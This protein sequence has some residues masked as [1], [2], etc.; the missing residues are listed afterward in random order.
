MPSGPELFTSFPRTNWR[1]RRTIAGPEGVHGS[2]LSFQVGRL[3]ER[4][5]RRRSGDNDIPW[6]FAG[7]FRILFTCVRAVPF[8]LSLSGPVCHPRTVA[9]SSQ[10]SLRSQ[11]EPTASYALPIHLF[12]SSLSP[13]LSRLVTLQLGRNFECK[14]ERGSMCEQC[15]ETWTSLSSRRIEFND[16]FCQPTEGFHRFIRKTL[17][18]ISQSWPRIKEQTETVWHRSKHNLLCY[19]IFASTSSGVKVLSCSNK[20]FC[21]SAKYLLLLFITK[22]RRRPRRALSS[23]IV[24]TSTRGRKVRRRGTW[25]KAHTK[26]REKRGPSPTSSPR[27][28]VYVRV[29]TWPCEQVVHAW[30]HPAEEARS[31]GAPFRT[32]GDP[33]RNLGADVVIHPASS[34]KPRHPASFQASH[35]GFFRMEF[36]GVWS[37][38][39]PRWPAWFVGFRFAPVF[40]SA[41]F[42]ETGIQPVNVGL[43]ENN[44]SLADDSTN[45]VIGNRWNFLKRTV[46]HER[47]RRM[48]RELVRYARKNRWQSDS[49]GK[50]NVIYVWCGRFGL[51]LVTVAKNN[52]K[53]VYSK[54][55]R[56]ENSHQIDRSGFSAKHCSLS[57]NCN[58]ISSILLRA[59]TSNVFWYFW[60]KILFY[61]IIIIFYYIIIILLYKS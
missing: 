36:Q 31:R 58:L 16:G 13:S 56:F 29:P 60:Y 19:N 49:F 15:R 6:W 25:P 5:S 57:L 14:L 47:K 44:G 39:P 50:I 18:G 7:W 8:S 51:G 1:N 37:S 59:P 38:K 30:E 41:L 2:L 20:Q 22:Q 40:F 45:I 21:E 48:H 52:Y 53:I 23:P 17:L 43:G 26:S 35:S 9:R 54:E 10:V 42:S 11:R 12:S 28:V 55:L 32:L 4:L 34:Y 46:T 61:Y 24:Q 3:K 27:G 33:F